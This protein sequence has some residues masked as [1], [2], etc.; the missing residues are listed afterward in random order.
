[1]RYEREMTIPV[2]RLLM[3]MGFDIVE[4]EV[5]AGSGI[6]DLVGIIVDKE[7]LDFRIGSSLF[8]KKNLLHF[9]LLEKCNGEWLDLG[10]ISS[11]TK[12]NPEK[13]RKSLNDLTPSYFCSKNDGNKILYRKK[14]CFAP[15]AKSSIA[16]ELKLRHWKRALVQAKRYFSVSNLSYVALPESSQSAIDTNEL[17]KKGIGLIYVTDGHEAYE[18]LEGKVLGAYNQRN[19]E[20]LGEC[21]W[22]IYCEKTIKR[23][24]R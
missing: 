3:T 17:A 8:F 24:T 4:R 20:Y 10:E 16:V 21:V 14:R 22:D 23:N 7:E 1:M 2:E 15:V 9:K 18:A 13:L 11:I 5:P 6:A 12:E 19:L